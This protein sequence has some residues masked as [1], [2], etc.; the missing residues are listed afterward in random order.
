[1]DPLWLQGDG[2]RIE[3]TTPHGAI[4]S[5]SLD[6]LFPEMTPEIIRV[7]IPERTDPETGETYPP[8]AYRLVLEA[9]RGIAPQDGYRRAVDDQ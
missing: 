8:R 5:A 7:A 4:L 1:M 3:I 6:L 9:V 2:C